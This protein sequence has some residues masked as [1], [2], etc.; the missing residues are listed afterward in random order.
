M[1]I[2]DKKKI[3]KWIFLLSMPIIVKTLFLVVNLFFIGFYKSSST[4]AFPDTRLLSLISHQAN[5][6]TGVLTNSNALVII[7][8]ELL[9]FS[10]PLLLAIIKLIR[11][12]KNDNIS[13]STFNFIIISLLIV[14][15]KDILI[16][17]MISILTGKFLL[18]NPINFEF[19]GFSILTIIMKYIYLGK[20][21]EK[22]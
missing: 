17:S 15:F 2:L 5:I 13:I 22:I 9:L 11:A 21:N 14:T 3:K 18:V 6:S 1:N 10:L 20:N 7:I 12:V 16:Q 4:D 8:L 19:L